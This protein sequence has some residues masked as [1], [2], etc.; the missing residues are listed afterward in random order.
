MPCSVSSM[1]SRSAASPLSDSAKWFH[2]TRNAG[3]SSRPI[4]GNLASGDAP[5]STG[6]C[7]SAGDCYVLGVADPAVRP[8][9]HWDATFDEALS[10]GDAKT[11]TLHI[12][13]SFGDVPTGNIFYRFIETIFHNSITGGCGPGIY[14]PGNS[15]LRKQMAAFVLKA[16]EGVEAGLPDPFGPGRL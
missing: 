4:G 10:T 6:D 5:Q 2:R 7:F 16:V 1:P 14:C 15:T 11:W 3:S 9:A 12:G 8:A 13:E